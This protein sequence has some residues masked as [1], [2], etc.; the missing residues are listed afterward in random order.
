MP[1]GPGGRYGSADAAER[2]L[3]PEVKAKY[4]PNPDPFNWKGIAAQLAREQQNKNSAQNR[5]QAA[6][7]PQVQAQ[8]AAPAKPPPS[9]K[10]LLDAY[11][12][13]NGGKLPPGTTPE[14]AAMIDQGIWTDWSMLSGNPQL[15]NAL[16]A[17]QSAMIQL[18]QDFAAAKGK[19]SADYENLTGDIL[20]SGKDWMK[21]L[22]GRIVDPNDPNS[23]LVKNDPALAGYAQSM[24]EL[25]E[26]ADLNQA[27]DLAWFEKML[28]GYGQD[29]KTLLL[30]MAAPQGVAGGG[31]GG[32][33]GRGGGGGGYGGGGGGDSDWSDPK[34]TLTN[35]ITG[36]DAATNMAT[37]YFPGFKEGLLTDAL[38]AGGPDLQAL[39]DTIWGSS[40]ETPRGM[41]KE[42][43]A[44]LME[45][46]TA[47]EDIG[48]QKGL[49]SAWETAAPASAQTA[50]Q[51]MLANKRAI[52]GDD[53]RTPGLK[54]QYYTPSGATNAGTPINFT[55]EQSEQNILGEELI[56]N[57]S[58]DNTRIPLAKAAFAKL[59]GGGWGFGSG[60]S[61]KKE[62]MPFSILTPKGE[63]EWRSGGQLTPG[64]LET[65]TRTGEQSLGAALR[66]DQS[67][68]KFNWPGWARGGG[69]IPEVEPG[70]EQ[71]HLAQ[72]GLYEKL[73]D[74]IE[75]YNPNV[76]TVPTKETLSEGVRSS[77]KLGTTNKTYDPLSA[78]T[79]TPENP[80]STPLPSGLEGNYVAN[81]DAFEWDPVTEEMV[82]VE[83]MGGGGAGYEIQGM[84]MA[85]NKNLS[86]ALAAAARDRMGGGPSM[87]DTVKSGLFGGAGGRKPSDLSRIRPKPIKTKRPESKPTVKGAGRMK[88]PRRYQEAQQT[89]YAPIRPRSRPTVAPGA[90]RPRY[91]GPSATSKFKSSLFG[92]KRPRSRGSTGTRN[93]AV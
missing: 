29:Y 74:L 24:N 5:V 50:I 69:Y 21:D 63:M 45:A 8:S 72:K 25:D 64:Q 16:L 20:T 39:A 46:D 31:G 7:A 41:T 43:Y 67:E 11:R 89:D 53:P 32:G 91:R 30:G 66:S 83:E 12:A 75:P 79:G 9:V 35:S 61:P 19:V 85:G 14:M 77:S 60:T 87:M 80:P 92:K 81:P 10:Q 17:V 15:A 34:T 47:L 84:Q 13:M 93:R 54:E 88:K 56:R 59:L 76:H 48:L 22:Y 68:N 58:P 49:R 44:R 86:S 1:V 6:S 18:P 36:T 78:L 2:Y 62:K 73:I 90:R 23:A 57:E 40:D 27:T 52:R 42:A 4:P 71:E 26:T 37:G 70:Q 3:T 82:P 55:P 28:A 65:L 33:G 38:A 51:A